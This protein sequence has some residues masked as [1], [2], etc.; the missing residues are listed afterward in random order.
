MLYMLSIL[1]ISCPALNA[2]AKTSGMVDEKRTRK[3][4][5]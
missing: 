4:G 1:F 2:F 5:R 3:F